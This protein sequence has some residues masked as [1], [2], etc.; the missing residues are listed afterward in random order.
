MNIAKIRAMMERSDA[1]KTLVEEMTVLM[2]AYTD[3]QKLTAEPP[4][5]G[6]IEVKDPVPWED[7]FKTM[8]DPQAQHMILSVF[9]T[10]M[11]ESIDTYIESCKTEFTMVNRKGVTNLVI[12]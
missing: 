7:M 9:L 10:K 6:D 12:A 1:M 11:R 4:K 2:N 3:I 8:S 5:A